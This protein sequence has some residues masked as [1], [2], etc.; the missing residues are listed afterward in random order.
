MTGPEDAT[1]A[2]HPGQV[3][4][5]AQE[6]QLSQCVRACSWLGPVCRL[7]WEVSVLHICE[8]Q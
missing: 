1:Q 2:M 5:A 3:L 7:E 6:A 4:P 8:Q